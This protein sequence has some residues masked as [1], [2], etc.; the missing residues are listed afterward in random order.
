MIQ[1]IQGLRLNASSARGAGLISG[2]GTKIPHA[3]QCSLKKKK[4]EFLLKTR[5]NEKPQ[6]ITD[7][8][9]HAHNDFPIC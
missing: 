3:M 9:V 6:Y 2:W 4:V 7:T 5:Q 1:V 8:Y